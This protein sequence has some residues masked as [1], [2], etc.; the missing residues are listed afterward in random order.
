MKHSDFQ[1]SQQPIYHREFDPNRFSPPVL[2]DNNTCR[3]RQ[4]FHDS[5]PTPHANFGYQNG[6]PHQAAQ[7]I[8]IQQPPQPPPIG[9]QNW[10]GSKN[11][12]WQP[13]KQNEHHQQ[14][15]PHSWGGE[16][17][18]PGAWPMRKE[19]WHGNPVHRQ[20][21][22][23]TNMPLT[24]NTTPQIT[25]GPASLPTPPMRD[26][27]GTQFILPPQP[28]QPTRTMFGQQQEPTP[29]DHLSYPNNA[30]HS[31]PPD[32]P[33]Q[34]KFSTIQHMDVDAVPL[35]ADQA[36]PHLMHSQDGVPFRKTSR[37]STTMQKE[38]LKSPSK[39]EKAEIV[40]RKASLM[41]TKRL[42]R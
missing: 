16:P 32:P 13:I 26:G 27:T 28:Y 3:P 8:P 24:V 2:D 6:Q 1:D 9:T 25:V 40:T 33:P 7:P 19:S 31:F 10:D 17:R 22:V 41:A 42:V 34:R 11:N 15:Q 23:V 21:S 37:S 12:N 36:S 38:S 20:Q 5:T 18:R 35:V 29:M 39:K 4:S 30:Q 14:P